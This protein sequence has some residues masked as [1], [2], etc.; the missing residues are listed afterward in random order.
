MGNGHVFIRS[1]A[2]ELCVRINLSQ[3][4]I[5]LRIIICKHRRKTYLMDYDLFGYFQFWSPD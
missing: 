1:S 4:E 2:I 5:C 3:N